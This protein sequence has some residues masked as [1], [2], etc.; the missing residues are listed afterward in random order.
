VQLPQRRQLF[1]DHPL[2]AVELQQRQEPRDDLQ[3]VG[4]VGGE[5]P[6]TRRPRAGHVVTHD[7]QLLG[8][9]DRRRVQVRDVDHLG[10]LRG[11][12]AGGQRGELLGG[13]VEQDLGHQL[14]EA[15]LQPD[16]PGEALGGLGLALAQETGGLLVG[17]VLQQ[18]GEEQ[19]AGLEE[20]EVLLVVDVGG[21]EQP[22][23]LE[24]EERGGHDQ[25]L[26]GLVEVELVAQ[27]AQVRDE[28]VGD[29]REGDL[30][31]VELVLP[32]QLQQQVERALEVG[33]PDRE[34]SRR[35]RLGDRRVALH[36]VGA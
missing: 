9:A 24:V 15:R 20:L 22:G 19:V 4:A 29:L 31:D 11:Q 3:R 6:E 17:L 16:L 32:D 21:R 27:G 2:L 8:D 5:R 33:Q 35:G 36:V 14:G 30:G 34:P 1:E 25:E 28:L 18:P 13:Q 10:H 7:Q 12:R 26:T 23:G